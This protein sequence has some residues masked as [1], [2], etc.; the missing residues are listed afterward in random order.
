MNI[1][2]A[3]QDDIEIMVKLVN[4]AYRGDFSRKGWTTEADLLAGTRVDEETLA[5]MMRGPKAAFL[6]YTDDAG[7]LCGCVYLQQQQKSMYLGMLTVSPE[8]QDQGIGKKLMKEAEHYALQRQCESIVMTVIS[9]RDVLIKWYE[10][11]GYQKTGETRPFPT[12]T[13]FGVAQQPLELIVLEKK[14]TATP[15]T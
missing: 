11:H 3:T 4:S 14:L 10:R 7:R 6:K 9:A 12:E 15:V 13:K 5:E 1:S 2:T 8:L